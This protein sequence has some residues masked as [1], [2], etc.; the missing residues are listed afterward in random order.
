MYLNIFVEPN[1]LYY[2]YNLNYWHYTVKLNL[3]VFGFSFNNLKVSRVNFQR[4]RTNH[5][6][7]PFYA[8]YLSLN[9]F[10]FYTRHAKE[11]KRIIAYRVLFDYLEKVFILSPPEYRSSLKPRRDSQ[12]LY[13]KRGIFGPAVLFKIKVLS[14]IFFFFLFCFT[15][16]YFNGI[17]LSIFILE[18]N[19]YL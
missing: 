17:Y 15:I 10:P 18:I 5:N 13:S 11:A 19:S 6:L 14:I 8:F 2:S 4:L 3:M 12:I 7:R 9:S 16:T 1:K